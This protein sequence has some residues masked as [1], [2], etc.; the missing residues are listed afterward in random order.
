LLSWPSKHDAKSETLP[1]CLKA[2]SHAASGHVYPLNLPTRIREDPVF[3][4]TDCGGKTVYANACSACHIK[5]LVGGPRLGDRTAW[6]PRLTKGVDTLIASVI[7]GKGVMQP[8][9]GV[10]SL[11]DDDIK[12]TVEYNGKP[13]QVSRRQRLDAGRDSSL[14]TIICSTREFGGSMKY[15]R[16]VVGLLLA[17]SLVSAR[18]QGQNANEMVATLCSKCHGMDGNSINPRY[19]NL[20]AQGKEYL[21]TQLR[22][23]RDKSRNDPDAHAFMFGVAELL[24][25]ELIVALADYFSNQKPVRGE[26]GDPQ[27]A[28]KGKVIHGEG[29]ASKHV[30]ACGWCHRSDAQGTT[31]VPRLAGQHAEYLVRQIK[32]FHQDSRPGLSATMKAV[33]QSITD[34]EAE[35]VAAY[36]QGL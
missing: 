5:G 28:A 16:L 2:N 35:Q 1:K 19:P 22:A 27:L 26:P 8:R 29:I 36:L 31:V 20:A 10:G 24:N 32:A 25:D 15:L 18:A 33:V 9:A 12:A 13:S 14:Y 34:E 6:A 21:V 30:P 11:S 4:C 23:F 17:I 3:L 7:T